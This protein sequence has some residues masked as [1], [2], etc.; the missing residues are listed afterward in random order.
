[1]LLVAFSPE[2]CIS[3]VPFN[4]RA[5]KTGFRPVSTPTVPVMH[6]AVLLTRKTPNKCFSRKYKVRNVSS[7]L[8]IRNTGNLRAKQYARHQFSRDVD[9]MPSCIVFFLEGSSSLVEARDGSLESASKTLSIRP[10]LFLECTVPSILQ[11]PILMSVCLFVCLYLRIIR[12]G[13]IH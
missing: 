6:R 3:Q 12:Y 8:N 13:S 1:M 2:P 5:M 10:H 9:H 7:K 11:L 4:G